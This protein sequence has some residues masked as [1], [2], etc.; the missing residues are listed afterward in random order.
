M[1]K[2][3]DNVSETLFNML[4][5]V[6]IRFGARKNSAPDSELIVRSEFVIF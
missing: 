6:C 5:K 2:I 1:L 3:L 4:D